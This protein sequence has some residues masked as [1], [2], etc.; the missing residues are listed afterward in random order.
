MTRPT[1]D[2]TLNK[3]APPPD[4]G[5]ELA[6]RRA[7]RLGT[8]ASFRRGRTPL[9]IVEATQAAAAVADE[10]AARPRVPPSA[11]REG[12]AWCCYKPVGTAAPEVLRI[13]AYLRETL[14]AEAWEVLL[15]RLADDD[16]RGRSP[17]PCPLLVGDRCIAYPVRPLTCRG[18]NSSDAR[19]CEQSLTPGRSS[20]VPMHLP[21]LRL[22]TFVLDGLRAGLGECG[23]DGSRLALTAALKIALRVPDAQERWLAGEAVFAPARMA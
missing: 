19:R 9:Q 7:Q 23:L 17:R 1:H 18:F 2:P 3:P 15:S 16:G 6:A 21:Q 4:Y 22:A 20:E 11:C 10:A 12:C 14:S 8:V 13:V 5:D